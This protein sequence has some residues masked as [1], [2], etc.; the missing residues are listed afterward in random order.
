MNGEMYVE[1]KGP[2]VL[3]GIIGATV[4]A[5]I[6]IA[7]WT[8]FAVLTERNIGYIAIA[9]GLAVGFF[10]KKM[11]KQPH[12]IVTIYACIVSVVAIILGNVVTVV[13]FVAKL[14]GMDFFEVISLLDYV[15]VVKSIISEMN[16]VD[17]SFMAIAVATAYNITKKPAQLDTDMPDL[18]P[19][20]PNQ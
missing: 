6:G 5:I 15:E 19:S 13:Y 11:S 7:V 16:F 12:H 18:T 14:A 20:E 9:I 3:G 8:L 17:L 4:G 10:A 1:K 2:N